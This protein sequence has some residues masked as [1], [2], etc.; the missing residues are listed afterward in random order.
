MSKKITILL[1]IF[2]FF[3][4]KNV[5]AVDLKSNASDK[6]YSSINEFSQNLAQG[7]ADKLKQNENLKYFDISLDLQENQKPTIEIQSVSK[8]KEDNDSAYFNQ[9][10]LSSYN[11]ETTINLGFG[12]RKLYKDETVMLGS[13]VFVDYQ[14]DESHLRN[15]LGVE[16]I[17]SVFDLRGNYY[18]A[19]SGFK[20]TDEG[21]EKA[22]DG[23]DIQLNYHV[24]G[25]NNT[26]LY[27]QTFEWENPNSSYK[28]KGEKFGFVSQIGN[29]NLNLG[30]VND[31][32]NN[33][34]FFAGVKLVVPLGDTN[35]N[36]PEAK[37]ESL[38]YVSVR[39]K[40][41]IPVKRENRIRVVKIS[42]SGVKLSGF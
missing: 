28:E 36:Q 29:L 18:N 40:L 25:K 38:Q 37:T 5:L 24:T 4:L 35:E 31:N 10:N 1:I 20:A 32:K 11:G 23:Y 14:F 17:S 21:R 34:G 41:Y 19:I 3:L 26:D 12:K 33:D 42:K 13:N 30:Y 6:F 27:L 15:G 39:E 2:S 22:L 9:T 8:L 16:A 7:L